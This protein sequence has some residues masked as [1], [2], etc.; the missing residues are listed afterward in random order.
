[1]RSVVTLAALLCFATISTSSYAIVNGSASPAAQDYVV[2]IAIEQKG[3]MVPFCT[4]TLIAKNLVITARHCTGELSADEESITSYTPTK[5]KFYFG[6]GAGPKTI[7]KTPEAQGKTIFTNGKKDLLPDIALVELDKELDIPIVPIRLGSSAAKG[8]A[9]DVVGYG[10]TEDHRYPN[11]RQQRKGLKIALVAP[12]KSDFFSLTDGE[13]QFGEAA[14]A[15][16]SGGPAL[17]A[18]TGALIGIAS[19]VTNGQARSDTEVASF[20][21]GSS[22]EDIYTDLTTAKAF[23][24]SAF[25]AVGATPW[26]EGEPSPEE[27]AAAAKKEEE[28]RQAAATKAAADAGCSTTARAPTSSGSAVMTWLA[29]L[30]LIGAFRSR[31]KRRARSECPPR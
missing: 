25:E 4:G 27:K 17:S 16:D 6:I 21:L 31:G 13:F 24:E 20:C 9:F 2:Q 7:D 19:R 28:N 12:G 8:E 18:E 26:L 29:A 15:G 30:G 3:K 10:L 22:A 23:I 11:V 14:C 5:L 1:M